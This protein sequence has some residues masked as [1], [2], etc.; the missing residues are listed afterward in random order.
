MGAE[1]R[2]DQVTLSYPPETLRVPRGE[3][4]C[5]ERINPSRDRPKGTVPGR[6]G[7]HGT[8]TG[9]GG[10]EF[11]LGGQREAP[12]VLSRASGCGVSSPFAAGAHVPGHAVRSLVPG[13]SPRP[14]RP[15]WHPATWEQ[16]TTFPSGRWHLLVTGKMG[17]TW[18]LPGKRSLLPGEVSLV[19]RDRLWKSGAESLRL[20]RL[21]AHP[22][23]WGCRGVRSPGDAARLRT[24]TCWWPRSWRERQ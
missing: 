23:P 24:G 18:P 11:C 17:W 10:E 16:V 8:A 9:A 19:A 14:L 15:P 1:A 12:R 6:S 3:R 4:V 21:G 2:E 5:R 22:G 7:C 20:V 13:D